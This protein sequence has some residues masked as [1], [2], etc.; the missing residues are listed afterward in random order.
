MRA[1][2]SQVED[3]AGLTWVPRFRSCAGPL[4][5]DG[6]KRDA[7]NPGRPRPMLRMEGRESLLRS[8]GTEYAV[9]GPGHW[10]R[11]ET[12]SCR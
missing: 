2:I 7:T 10:K 8:S 3:V 5:K 9:S 12:G 1:G 6:Q 11:L 4:R